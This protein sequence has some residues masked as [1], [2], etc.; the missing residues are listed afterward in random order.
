MFRKSALRCEKHAEGMSDEIFDK[1]NIT[2]EK[3]CLERTEDTK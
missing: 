3:I 1:E 2:L